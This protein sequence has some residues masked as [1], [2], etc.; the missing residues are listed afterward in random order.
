[1]DALLSPARD[2]RPRSAE[3]VAIALERL[4]GEIGG[5]MRWLPAEEVGPFRGLG[6]FEKEDRD[7]F[8]GR[9]ADIAA[10]VEML[11]SRGLV[12]VEEVGPAAREI[13][14]QL[15]G[16]GAAPGPRDSGLTPAHETLLSQW[17]QLRD[18][19]A[20]ARRD[21]LLA[22]ELEQA[23]ARHEAEPDDSRLWKKRQLISAEDLVRSERATQRLARG[24][25]PP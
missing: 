16:G 2:K 19:L 5:R 7:V 23:A 1:V 25:L 20:E 3:L 12:A 15:A 6:R 24:A 21:R 18:W 10:A 13:V 8:F 22:E 4:R 11:R 17:G 9:S 14:A